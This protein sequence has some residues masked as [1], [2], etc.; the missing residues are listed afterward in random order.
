MQLLGKYLSYENNG[1]NST[2]L[3]C[4]LGSRRVSLVFHKITF[5]H[6]KHTVFAYGKVR[7]ISLAATEFWKR[8][9]TTYCRLYMVVY[10]K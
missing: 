7:N 9:V 2:I 6:C 3:S 4:S 10:V 5:I 8:E 1:N